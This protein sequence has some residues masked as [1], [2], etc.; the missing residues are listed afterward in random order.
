V[1]GGSATGREIYTRAALGIVLIGAIAG[2]LAAAV[3]ALG[4]G[5]REPLDVRV[6]RIAIEARAAAAPEAD[7]FA[8]SPARRDDFE[9]RAALGS[10]H[11]IYA[12]SPGGVVASARRTA[13]FRDEVEA[14]ALSHGIDPDTLEAVIFLESAGRP[15]VAAGPTPES[16]SGLAQ[17]L[18]STATD[19]LGMQVDLPRSIELTRR[20][21]AAKTP[22]QANRLRA[23]RAAI[24]QRFDPDAALDGAARYL[25]I[26][27]ER[28]GADDLAVASYHMGIGNLES[29]IRAY[30]DAGDD[31]PIGEVVASEGLSYAQLYF[32]SSPLVHGDA[33]EI[34]HGFGDESADYL[35]KVEASRELM[36]EYRKDAEALGET[37]RLATAKATLE[38]LFHPEA[39]TDVF[40]D[41]GELSDAIDDGEL[42]PLPFEAGLGWIPAKQMGELAP[43]LDQ[44][45][46]LYRALR[47]EAL[48]TLSYLAG[49]VLYQSNDPTPLLV[50]SSV[51]D[52]SYQELLIA[53]NPQA[54]PE[55]S[56]HTTGW[57][58]DIKREYASK[59]QAAAFQHVIDR[60]SALGLI[61]Y[62]VEPGAIHITVSNLGAELVR[63]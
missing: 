41:P 39:E 19:L 58:F 28:F 17:I 37:A 55:Y 15:D 56:L 42:V 25:E 49:L 63:R 34:L 51:R 11:V 59:E 31:V 38:E 14:A 61:D 5:E 7:P 3:L 20:I 30:A 54:T 33:Y 29:V 10:S 50:T 2:A 9:D 47:P 21:A 62:A 36:A 12:M 13:R 24:D 8:W 23:E 57:S 52:R 1:G 35:W 53:S 40:D 18:P 27:S 6:A 48:A 26:A 45:P 46:R 16:A 43:Q 32:D 44:D 4:V 22:E 60:L